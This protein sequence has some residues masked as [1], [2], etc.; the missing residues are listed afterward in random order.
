MKRAGCL[1]GI[2]CPQSLPRPIPH[3]SRRVWSVV[4]AAIT[5]ATLSI[6]LAANATRAAPVASGVA[7]LI[8]NAP[9]VGAASSS[10][11]RSLRKYPPRTF[12]DNATSSASTVRAAG[13][14]SA[15]VWEDATLATITKARACL[16]NAAVYL[17]MYYPQFENAFGG[18]AVA[19]KKVRCESLILGY[20]YQLLNVHWSMCAAL[21]VGIYQCQTYIS[22]Y[23]YG[24]SSLLY[25][26]QFP[27]QPVHTMRK[28]CEDALENMGR[29][30]S[31][32]VFTQFRYPYSPGVSCLRDNTRQALVALTLF[33]GL[34]P[35]P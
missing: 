9:G 29:S 14:V 32:K 33:P 2:H 35:P 24:P 22:D 16:A 18:P 27:V 15:E 1:S 3:M 10:T 20:T 19:D 21:S 26:D 17:S 31:K 4:A 8:N 23:A 6:L 11:V 28:A 12:G 7:N 5:V 13:T 25:P 34:V 30:A